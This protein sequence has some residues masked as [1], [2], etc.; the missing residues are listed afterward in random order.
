M[1]D[2][3]IEINTKV[4]KKY[5]LKNNFV[6][7]FSLLALISLVFWASGVF[8]FSL[9]INYL[10]QI[11]GFFSPTIWF[12]L[13]VMLIFSVLAAYHEKW[14]L[15]IIPLLIWLLVTTA[16]VRTSNIPNLVNAATG[17]PVLGPDLDP[18]LFT[19]NAIE[20]SQGKNLGEFD[21]MRAAPFGG[22]SYIKGNMMP[23]V[24]FYTYKVANIFTDAS[25][26]EAAIIAPVIFFLLSLM[27]FFLF[28]YVLFSFKLSRNKALIG[29]T[30]ASFL[31]AFIPSMLHRTTAGIPELE[32]LGIVWF[33][34]AF[35]FFTLSW[36]QKFKGNSLVINKKLIGYGL[37]A[38]IFTGA[39]SWTWGG[40]KYIYLV[41]ASVSFLVFLFE[42]EKVKNFMIYFSWFVPAIILEILNNGQRALFNIS[43]GTGLA[44]GIFVLMIVNIILFNTQLKNKLKL[45]KIRL[46]ETITTILMLFILGVISLLIINPSALIET[47]S[48][49]INS[50][51]KPF[52][53]S[54][55]GTT[56]AENRI[57]YLIEALNNFG[58]IIWLFFFGLIVLFYESTKHF[59]KEKKLGLNFFF[60]IFISSFMFSSISPQHILN[61]Q[62]FISKTLYLGGLLVF[63]GFLIYIYTIAYKTRDEKTLNDF[64]KI[65]ISYLI[66]LVFAFFGLMFMRSAIRFFFLVSPALI[67]VASYL[68][69]KI[70]ENVKKV[71][72]DLT[73]MVLW[74]ILIV[75]LFV[76]AGTLLSY[77]GG[78][79]ISAK[80]I[81]PSSYNQQWHYAMDWVSENTPEN[82]IFTHWWDY[83]YWVQ[84]LGNRATVADGGYHVRNHFLGR[85][86]L[87]TKNPD[88]ALGFMNT[89]NVTHLLIDSTDVGKYPAFSKIGS[90]ETGKD[91]F[92]SI[93]VMPRDESQT[94]ESNESVMVV[95]GGG[96]MI[97]NDIIYTTL[98]N[99]E[100][101]LPGERTGL[102]AIILSYETKNEDASF[103]QPEGIFV[104]NNERYDI[105]LR[106]IYYNE[107]IIDFE[108]GIE[109]IIRIVPSLQQNSQGVSINQIGAVIYLSEKTKDT[110]F[111]QLY[112][113]DDLENRYP[114]I[115]LTHIE[116]DLVV[117]SL[118]RQGLDL[119]SFLYYQGLR[120]PIKIWRVNYPENTP[121]HEEYTK[122][123]NF[124]KDDSWG[125]FDYL[126]K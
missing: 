91:R 5:L 44:T 29:A 74:I 20:I 6:L 60:I 76:V 92:A 126:G 97:N 39:M 37:L 19:R 13:S 7:V 112:L 42:K 95:F 51:F 64:K 50:F 43:A 105:P 3:T 35:L 111:S 110:L 28:T 45:K 118:K 47:F 115:T 36:K 8:E 87:T 102:A 31:Y 16:I 116:D 71:G 27:G 82:A 33:W 49:V 48:S 108:T 85:Y 56:V 18:Y 55:V 72:D 41:I 34:L 104:Y 59:S 88:T 62:S 81:A 17:E 26:M 106:Y 52:G 101:F 21:Q 40:Y 68:P 67:I 58:N 79:T 125:K 124:D 83:G 24:I 69:F 70:S 46:P 23:W 96:Q 66:L 99:K 61:G 10:I 12:F 122:R 78:T 123:Y 9:K 30:L 93:P 1:S 14:I 80:N 73:K 84:T 94:Q 120:G 103:N 117:K 100:I 86:M 113:L 98:E 107:K 38:G 77:M 32:S 2:E 54:R 109:S 114:T 4:I 63:L 15:M 22:P 25:V 65:G 75:I 121:R 57:P 90:D 89:F 53:A 119:G 11:V